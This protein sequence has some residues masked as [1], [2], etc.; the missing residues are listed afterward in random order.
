M[1]KMSKCCGN[2]NKKAKCKYCGS[3]NVEYI[4]IMNLDDWRWKCMDCRKLDCID[5][6]SDDKSQEVIEKP[7]EG[8]GVDEEINNMVAQ[9]CMFHGDCKRNCEKCLTKETWKKQFDKLYERKLKSQLY[10]LILTEADKKKQL[11]YSHGCVSE[12][13][14]ITVADLVALLEKMFGQKGEKNDKFRIR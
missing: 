6:K 13:P 1:S 7:N 2:V 3:E 9:C 5:D 12:F 8:V 11:T 4:D 10:S 14:Y